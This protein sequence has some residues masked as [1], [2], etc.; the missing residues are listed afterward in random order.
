M[1]TKMEEVENI[2]LVVREPGKIKDLHE[3]NVKIINFKEKNQFI[4]EVDS[5]I[6][7]TNAP[8]AVVLKDDI[9]ER[10]ETL[11]IFD[12]AVPRDVEVEVGLLNKVKVYNIDEISEVDDENKAL[13]VQRMSEYKYIY[14]EY[15]KEYMEWKALREISPIIKELKMKGEEVYSK[16]LNTYQNKS[17]DLKD[18]GLVK[19]LL[20]STSDAYINRAIEVIKNETLEGSEEECLRIVRKIFLTEE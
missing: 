17:R 13:R 2:Y 16:R 14:E 10:R 6:S 8:H 20:K 1:P 4:Q 3:E 18:E 7:C 11:S 9:V 19:M 15:L 5:I 12:M